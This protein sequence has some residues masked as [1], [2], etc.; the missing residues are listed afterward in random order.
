MKKIRTKILSV[1]LVIA[2]LI[3]IMPLGMF[4]LTAS[5]SDDDG[6][7]LIGNHDGI[8]KSDA[9]WWEIMCLFLKDST[10]EYKIRLTEGI[11]SE[12]TTQGIH[13]NVNIKGIK[14][15]D[16]NGHTI[17]ISYDSNSGGRTLFDIQD[18]AVFTLDDS[19]GDN[20]EVRYDCPLGGNAWQPPE[21]NPFSISEGGEMIMN[22]GA[23][24]GGHSKREYHTITYCVN[25]DE[26]H[27]GYFRQQVE[28]NGITVHD[29]AKLV[30]NG[31][32][33]DGRGGASIDFQNH[34]SISPSANGAVRALKG[35]EVTINDS[36]LKGQGGS[37]ALYAQSGANIK[38]YSCHFQVRKVDRIWTGNGQ[39]FK[40]P[41]GD[42]GISNTMIDTSKAQI[43]SGGEQLS[44]DSDIDGEKS[45]YVEPYNEKN[46]KCAGSVTATTSLNDNM[47]SWTI[48]T[49]LNITAKY[50]PYFTDSAAAYLDNDYYDGSYE[51]IYYNFTLLDKSFNALSVPW[52]C[53][54]YD[55]YS[56]S[57]DL[58]DYTFKDSKGNDISY[59]SG[60]I[61]YI[62]VSMS[63]TWK[64]EQTH[65]LA[66]KCN[67]LISPTSIVLPNL[68]TYY[69]QTTQPGLATYLG[70]EEEHKNAEFVFGPTQ[71]TI[72][73][74]DESSAVST[75][76]CLTY[77]YYGYKDAGGSLA[78]KRCFIE[79]SLGETYAPQ[80]AGVQA[81]KTD[82]II[83]DTAGKITRPSYSTSVFV[84]PPTKA[85][86]DGTNYTDVTTSVIEPSAS[87]QPVYLTAD[88]DSLMT[89]DFGNAITDFTTKKSISLDSLTWQVWNRTTSS[90]DTISENST[91]Y[92]VD[93][94]TKILTVNRTGRYRACY[95]YGGGLFY[96]PI[97]AWIGG[98]DYETNQ[99]CWADPAKIT[100]EFGNK[101]S[102]DIKINTDTAPWSSNLKYTMT[103]KEQPKG[104]GANVGNST[105]TQ[106]TP[107]FI[108]DDFF[109]ASTTAEKMVPGTY[110]F[111]LRVKDNETGSEYIAADCLS[112]TY[113][114]AA[115]DFN[116][117]CAGT[118]LTK[119]A[120]T[121]S[122]TLDGDT[123][124]CSFSCGRYP[125]N[126]T[127]P[128]WTYT[129]KSLDAD[130]AVITSNGT[131]TALRPGTV[132]L[133]V[134]TSDKAVK[135]IALTIPIAGFYIEKPTFTVGKLY[136][137]V[138]PV[139]SSVWSYNGIKVTSNVSKYI[140]ATA[141]SLNG[142]TLSAG[143]TDGETIAYNETGSMYFTVRTTSSYEFPI[144]MTYEGMGKADDMLIETNAFGN[145]I[146]SSNQLE[147]YGKD[148]AEDGY[149]PGTS[150]GCGDKC[151]A[152]LYIPYEL[153][154]IR[155]PSAV[156][157]DT[158]TLSTAEPAVGDTRYLGA[159]NGKS[160]TCNN[161]MNVNFATLSQLSVDGYPDAKMISVVT[162]NSAKMKAAATG[163]GMPYDDASTDWD[164]SRVDLGELIGVMIDYSDNGYT[165]KVFTAGTYVHNLSFEINSLFKS[166]GK[167]YYFS[168]DVK[169]YVNGHNVKLSYYA[170]NRLSMY[171][172]FDV[173]TV[174][175]YDKA[176]VDGVTKP[177]AGEKPATE[178]TASVRDNKDI[179]V[180][181]ITWFVDKDGDGKLDDMTVDS[182]GKITDYGEVADAYFDSDGNYDKTH[183]L[184]SK[185]GT[186]LGNKAYSVFV[187]VGLNNADNRI[188]SS[189][190]ILSFCD[191]GT[192]KVISSTSQSGNYTFSKTGNMVI[193][194]FS[195][196]CAAKVGNAATTSALTA[197]D[198]LTLT[199]CKWK[200][201]DSGDY[202]IGNL[203]ATDYIFE[204]VY[205]AD[206]GYEVDSNITF[207]F[208]GSPLTNCTE[209]T[210]SGKTLS[211]ALPISL[212]SIAYGSIS[213]SLTVDN[214]LAEVNY[215][216]TNGVN[217]Y[218]KTTKG[219]VDFSFANIAP[220][221]YTITITADGSLGYII[222]NVVVSGGSTTELD[223]V[224]LL[225][226]DANKDAI[227]SVA[228]ISTILV[229]YES[230]SLTSDVNGDGIISVADI[231]MVLVGTRYGILAT[232]QSRILP[233]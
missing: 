77:A 12:G 171:Y 48:G 156:Y 65:I 63:D 26:S 168:P 172:Y 212:G 139:I 47:N 20:G 105:K 5:A 201:A 225:F 2:M 131:V 51:K 82:F 177:E 121:G 189:N 141:N 10:K 224:P 188:D 184:L 57:F 9:A 217:T 230:Y 158:V 118:N 194:D 178:N 147:C 197:P 81:L 211:I 80:K 214:A 98:N 229:S 27:V 55:N 64:S 159:T 173:G 181:R 75:W 31:G 143:A 193:S 120:A 200:N 195:S 101:D 153:S 142:D 102:F 58:K 119:Q 151:N 23:V 149:R 129:W 91:A 60:E 87:G 157:V 136:S 148:S 226:G 17:S 216:I 127:Y 36:Y 73:A 228:D 110:V 90:W 106:T 190:F 213:G 1:L 34:D 125:E 8:D 30:L 4:S 191:S 186:F 7:T 24:I 199:S 89:D 134:T 210:D 112:V 21:R 170:A 74:L 161:F 70:K 109:R 111:Q 167:N 92:S 86:T 221:T 124:T 14:T 50:T 114:K 204:A 76:D 53:S 128:N 123:N 187:E 88:I 83:R 103:L 56:Y 85:S 38:V 16:L 231:S 117:Y 222:S 66:P 135:T 100:T 94:E 19:T 126:S 179:D 39:Y 18:S 13:Y 154:I 144:Y 192:D 104:G 176:T 3:G 32:Q 69:S 162:S 97:T 29:S 137:D 233:N 15:L 72:D 152:A 215:S 219:N 122:Y 84:M 52:K 41:Y 33:I 40:C 68:S 6:W 220:G 203:T 202:A 71:T 67:V 22:G 49:S 78:Y 182:N 42:L 166:D 169:I 196:D 54:G 209:V 108:V 96:S 93:S 59:T 43:V 145:T 115:T 227:I 99:Q 11:D 163:S 95:S 133:Q 130:I 35:S 113:K 138:K 164:G 116:V 45:A 218:S 150:G 205:T 79:S 165:D 206:S 46:G 107:T 37:N 61:Y 132:N 62:Q 146:M 28:S 140:S 198:G 208:N 174:N 44:E 175:S 160:T 207:N 25:A 232:S 183:S 155:D 223:A 180:T 185:D